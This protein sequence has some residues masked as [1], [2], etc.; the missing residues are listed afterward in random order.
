MGRRL[1]A[2]TAPRNVESRG[3]GRYLGGCSNSKLQAISRIAGGT[4]VSLDQEIRHVLPSSQSAPVL[5]NGAV[6]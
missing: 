6:G 5:E 3:A 2:K 4:R 1:C